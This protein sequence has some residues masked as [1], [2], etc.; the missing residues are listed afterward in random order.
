MAWRLPLL[1]WLLPLGCG[2]ALATEPPIV[3]L[4][5][6]PSGKSVLACS[7]S[8]V[9]VLAWPSLKQTKMV[10]LEDVP[11][12]H[13]ISFS[14]SGSQI[15]IGG[16]TPSSTGEVC[17]YRLPD[18]KRVATLSR[19]SD[20]VMDLAWINETTLVSASLDYEVVVWDIESEKS[21]SVL[22]GHSRGVTSLAIAGD[23]LVSSGLDQ[24]L[25][26][27][28]QK[29]ATLTRSLSIHTLPVH[30]LATRPIATG[31][32]MVA[33]A[34]EDRS[35]R[36]WQ[37]SIGRMVRFAR[38]NAKPL[39]IKWMPSGDRIVAACTDGRL[40][41]IDPDTVEIVDSAPA[42]N[43]WAYCLAIHP[44]SNEIVVAGSGGQIAVRKFQ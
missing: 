39:S 20:S 30:D 13:C 3:D 2:L 36:F 8:G 28:D 23:L 25:R 22:K 38:L 40:Y 43:G 12:L 35:V 19:H 44:T 17:V 5:F 26:I 11:N 41:L 7:Q 33:S 29:S 18:W 27:W 24:S 31:L 9:Q 34:S 4:E 16:G 42:I 37:P 21:K 6:A 15:A 32:P 14:P 10:S 1:L